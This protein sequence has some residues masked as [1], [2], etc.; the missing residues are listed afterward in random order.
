MTVDYGYIN[1]RLRWLGAF[2]FEYPYP[3]SD[4]LFFP[5]FCLPAQSGS[6]S[7]PVFYS[8]CLACISSLFGTYRDRNLAYVE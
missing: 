3:T 8:S 5:A 7:L 1:T 4:L 2:Y 6:S